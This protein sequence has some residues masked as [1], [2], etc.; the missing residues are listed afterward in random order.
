MELGPVII[1]HRFRGPRESANGGYVSGLLARLLGAAGTEVTLRRPPPLDRELAVRRDGDR[2]L[3][4]DGEALLAEARPG[5]PALTPPSPPSW[6]DALAAGRSAGAWNSGSEPQTPAAPEFDE[7]FVCGERPEHDGLGLHAGRVAGRPELVAT[8][9]VPCEVAP[10]I[11]WAAIDCA[12]AYALRG[13]GRR[14]PLLARMTARIDRLPHEGERCVVI[15]WPLDADGRKRH[16]GTALV[17]ED[18]TAI[19]VSRQL[20]IEPRYA[21][22]RADSATS[23]PPSSS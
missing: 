13:E 10:E 6:D 8:T 17:G 11:V 20:W 1:A 2:L 19:A 23:M 12:G 16:A 15:G 14:E 3:L 18:G 21:S 5:D 4:L 22:V 7:C 9:W